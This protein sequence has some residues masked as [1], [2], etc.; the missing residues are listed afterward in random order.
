MSKNLRIEEEK[1][2]IPI[3]HMDEKSTLEH[4]WSIAMPRQN[5]RDRSLMYKPSV[6]KQA[7]GGAAT[8]PP[9]TTPNVEPVKLSEWDTLAHKD[10]ENF[11]AK[12]P[13]L[14]EDKNRARL[15]AYKTQLD[16]TLATKNPAAWKKVHSQVKFD[17]STP[18]ADRIAKASGYIEDKTYPYSLNEQDMRS[19]LGDKYDDFNKLRGA[20]DQK[21]GF[22]AQGTAEKGAPIASTAYGLRNSFGIVPMIHTSGYSAS[23]APGQKPIPRSEIT[24]RTAY[25]TTKNAY[26]YQYDQPKYYPAT[27]KRKKGGLLR[28]YSSKKDPMTVEETAKQYEADRR[29]NS[30]LRKPDMVPGAASKS[31]SHRS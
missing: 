9:T 20:Y 24:A 28:G 18:I 30:S 31:R 4:L 7:N 13:T 1:N 21:W 23:P 3:T 8:E 29:R 27:G 15:Y 16:S 10:I 25:D 2:L 26:N 6:P 5:K 11:K 17:E 19:T 14:E 22:G 12:L